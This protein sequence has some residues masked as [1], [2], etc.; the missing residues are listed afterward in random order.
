ML[1][2][3]SITD[4][5][6]VLSTR[7]LAALKNGDGTDDHNRHEDSQHFNQNHGRKHRRSLRER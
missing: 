6:E 3:P 5:P 4:S 7:T 2:H 1:R